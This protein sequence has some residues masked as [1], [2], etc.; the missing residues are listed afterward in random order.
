M[1]RNN[2]DQAQYW[3]ERAEAAL[4]AAES[5]SDSKS[6]TKLLGVA[7]AYDTIAKRAEAKIKLVQN[8][9]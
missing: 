7:K 3:R 1:R 6:K 4:T 2:R 5:V 9:N 8:S